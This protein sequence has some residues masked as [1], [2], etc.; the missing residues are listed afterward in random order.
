MEHA[1]RI[2]ALK[3]GL[4]RHRDAFRDIRATLAREAAELA[5][6]AADGERVIPEIDFAALESGRVAAGLPALV[7]RRGCVVVRG[8][9]PAAQAAAWDDEIA[10]YLARNDADARSHA[11]RPGRWGGGPPQMYSVYWSPPQVRARQSARM[12]AVRRWLNR[13]WRWRG[14][15]DPD[16]DCTYADRIRR[17]TPGDT[18]LGLGPHIDGGTAGRWLDPALRHPYRAVFAGDLAGFD[19]FDAEGRTGE[20]DSEDKNACS[21]FR[22]WQGWTALTAQGPG[23]GTLQVVPLAHAIAGV[24]LRPLLA[25]VP[26]SSLCGAE[27]A[28]ALRLSPEWHADLLRALLP[29]PLVASGDS[30]WWHP[31]LIH[32]VEAHHAGSAASNVMYIGAA[33]ACPRNRRFL[34]AQ[35]AAFRA[36]R[37]PPDFPADDLEA[38]FA[39]R[40]GPDLLDAAGRRQMGLT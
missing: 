7:G 18:S 22:S 33:P 37:S 32:A 3:A 30:V 23:C 24:L 13:L 21:A 12:A 20:A 39:G 38:D 14:H 35:L 15:F 34:P 11:L 25:D 28:I 19:P 26:E 2:A 31:D 5:D 29:V 27:S 16:E 6:R 1:A 10:D 9:F 8:T 4:A 36:G 17:R 40:A